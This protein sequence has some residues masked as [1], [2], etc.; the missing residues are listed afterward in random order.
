MA[1]HFARSIHSLSLVRCDSQG[2]KEGGGGNEHG[3]GGFV[4]V[5]VCVYVWVCGEGRVLAAHL[6]IFALAVY[7]VSEGCWRKMGTALHKLKRHAILLLPL[8]KGKKSGVPSPTGYENIQPLNWKFAN[9]NDISDNHFNTLQNEFHISTVKKLIYSIGTGW[10][11][12]SRAQRG[13]EMRIISANSLLGNDADSI[14]CGSPFFIL[15]VQ[16][17]YHAFVLW[18]Y[19]DTDCNKSGC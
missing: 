16:F 5:F 10:A 12:S 1:A 19:D 6:M 15:C 18:I 3:R 17:A 7:W 14:T 2:E 13:D 11:Y 8:W 9:M 4:C